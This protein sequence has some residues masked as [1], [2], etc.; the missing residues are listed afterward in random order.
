MP[1]NGTPSTRENQQRRPALEKQRRAAL[2]D[3]L[4]VAAQDEDGIGPRQLM[5]DVMVV[6]ERLRERAG[7]IVHRR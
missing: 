2:R 3:R 4:V 6:P 5:V 7:S 1:G